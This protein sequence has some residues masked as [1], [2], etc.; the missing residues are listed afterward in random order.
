MRLVQSP[1]SDVVK[2]ILCEVTY[3]L[4]THLFRL[5]VQSLILIKHL[6]A[7]KQCHAFHYDRKYLFSLIWKFSHDL[8]DLLSWFFLDWPS[9]V[10]PLGDCIELRR[11]GMGTEVPCLQILG[12]GWPS[13]VPLSAAL[14]S[15]DF[16]SVKTLT[17]FSGL[18]VLVLPRTPAWLGVG[19]DCQKWTL[20]RSSS[21]RQQI[22][23]FHNKDICSRNGGSDSIGLHRE[24]AFGNKSTLFMNFRY[25]EDF[26]FDCFWWLK[27]SSSAVSLRRQLLSLALGNMSPDDGVLSSSDLEYYSGSFVQ[28]FLCY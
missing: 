5:V 21:F 18:S 23:F 26:C 12:T 4:V 9:D 1:Q 7:Q 2:Q 22:C 20:H 25:H 3:Q 19:S 27:T 14:A 28:S 17:D 24:L 13:A 10:S 8:S 16:G 15:S 11:A 6:R